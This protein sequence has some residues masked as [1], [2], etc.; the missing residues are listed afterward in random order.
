MRP[1]RSLP[2]PFLPSRRPRISSL[3][4]IIGF[5]FHVFIPEADPKPRK[6]RAATFSPT[7]GRRIRGDSEKVPRGYRKPSCLSPRLFSYLRV[8]LDFLLSTSSWFA[9]P[10][11]RLGLNRPATS[12]SSSSNQP[13]D[14]YLSRL[15]LNPMC[16][17]YPLTL[18]VPR[19]LVSLRVCENITNCIPRNV[20]VVIFI[21][22]FIIIAY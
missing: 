18:Q 20:R 10:R 16:A 3:G 13:P 22:C 4:Y 1:G 17:L 21:K 12:F 2:L 15:T 19:N 14:F 5:L 7:T 11:R 9:R 8:A 6:H